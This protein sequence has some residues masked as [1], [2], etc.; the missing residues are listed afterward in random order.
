MRG[1]NVVEA[2]GDAAQHGEVEPDLRPEGVG[3]GQ[4]LHLLLRPLQVFGDELMMRGGIEEGGGG[5]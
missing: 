4:L 2:G 3:G 5:L 1:A